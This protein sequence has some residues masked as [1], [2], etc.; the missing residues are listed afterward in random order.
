MYRAM[1]Q[2]DGIVFLGPLVPRPPETTTTTTTRAPPILKQPGVEPSPTTHP[3]LLKQASLPF[4]PQRESTPATIP[5]IVT[6][7][8]PAADAEP[9]KSKLPI[10]IAAGGAVLVV[11]F[12]L[13]RRR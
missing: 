4:G 13:L 12:F 2:D 11:G 3:P 1:G 7:A 6:D 8:A 10:Y 5:G 9:P